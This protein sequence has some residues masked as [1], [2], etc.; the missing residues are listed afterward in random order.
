MVTHVDPHDV[1]QHYAACMTVLQSHARLPQEGHA[2]LQ[3][4]SK[5]KRDVV[6]YLQ[7]GHTAV[8]QVS[9]VIICY[10]TIPKFLDA[11]KL[12]CNLPKIQ[13]KRPN[14]EIFCQNYEN[15]MADSEDADQTAPLRAV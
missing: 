1:R 5:T 9:A 13:T 14:L 10:R 8:V 15:G 12:C 4:C 2:H 7:W 11:K 6:Q 3:D